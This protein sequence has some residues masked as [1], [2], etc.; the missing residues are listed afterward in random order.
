MP[1]ITFKR[2]E[3]T[4]TEEVIS[5]YGDSCLGYITNETSDR[6]FAFNQQ[7]CS[8]EEIGAEEL[9][10]IASRIEQLDNKYFPREVSE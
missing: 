6:K 9:R 2:T 10:F 3:V 1:E 4:V 5:S 7:D 8:H